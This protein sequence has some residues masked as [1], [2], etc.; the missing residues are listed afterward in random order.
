MKLKPKDPA[1]SAALRP[2]PQISSPIVVMER[3]FEGLVARLSPEDGS[4]PENVAVFKA[5]FMAG[6]GQGCA[7][8]AHNSALVMARAANAEFQKLTNEPIVLPQ[9]NPGAPPA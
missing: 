2:V 8:I 4:D 7:Q 1:K 9:P 5:Y 3:E 6:W